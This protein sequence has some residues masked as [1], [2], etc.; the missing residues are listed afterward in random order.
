MEYFPVA[1]SLK[2]DLLELCVGYW[3]T[4]CSSAIHE[5]CGGR[6]RFIS[7]CNDIIRHI[8]HLHIRAS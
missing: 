5:E 6:K 8:L 7:S 2:H 3:L 1:A 4:D